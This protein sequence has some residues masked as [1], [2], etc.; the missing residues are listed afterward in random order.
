MRNL[1]TGGAGFLGSNICEA[2]LK[3]DE[4]VVCLDDLTSGKLSNLTTL[5]SKIF[6]FIQ[7][8]VLN[9]FNIEVDQIWHL[10]C[11]ASPTQY[12]KIY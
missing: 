8:S 11:P 12:I 9:D 4:Y 6:S 10:A 1:V 5:K 3:K 7:E 2:L